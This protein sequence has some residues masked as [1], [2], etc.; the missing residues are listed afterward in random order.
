MFSFRTTPLDEQ[1]DL[2]LQRGRIGLFCNQAAWNPVTGLYRFE[3]WAQKGTLKKVFYPQSGFFGEYAEGP[4]STATTYTD[5]LAAA[6]AIPFFPLD[7]SPDPA[8][9]EDLDALIIE[10]QD[11]GARYDRTPAL[12]YHLFAA[13]HKAGSSI[14][15]YLVDKA[16][17]AGRSVEGTPF[18]PEKRND[19]CDR[20]A[21]WLAHQVIG[22]PHRHGLTLGELANLFHSELGA[23]FP[24]HIISAAASPA[25]GVL[26]PWTIPPSPDVAGLF[27]C[28]FYSGMGLWASTNLSDGRGTCLPYEQVGAPYLNQLLSYNRDHGYAGWN[29]PKHP[30]YDDAVLLRWTRFTPALGEYAFQVCS[31]FQWLPVP[32][33]SFHAL[34]HTLR[35]MR[36][37]QEHCPEFRLCAGGLGDP[38]LQDYVS[39]GGDWTAIREHIKVEEQKWIRRAKRYQLYE[40]SLWRIKSLG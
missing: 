16:N 15:V 39:R 9:F 20:T 6:Q 24:L 25:S 40:D 12:L 32:G 21:D 34:A 4:E 26:M 13:L 28:G 29:D 38:I 2:V 18:R 30:L 7:L 36:F 8:L 5:M 31:G 14:S 37:F 17:P 19:S 10:L 33:A 22:L 1:P 27:T 11:T 3:V 35:M 23:K